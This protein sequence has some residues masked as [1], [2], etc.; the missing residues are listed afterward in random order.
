V[1][2]KACRQAGVAVCNVRGYSTPSVAQHTIALALALIE[3]L[4]Y[5][6]QFVKSGAY[7]GSG[8]FT[9]WGR[10]FGEVKG[11]TWGIFGMGAI[12]AEV[13]KVAEA[14]GAKVIYYSTQGIDRQPTYDR[15]E[16]EDFLSESDILSIHAPLNQHTSGRFGQSAFQKMKPHAVLLN[17]GRGGIVNIPELV[18]GPGD[19]TNC[20]SRFGRLPPKNLWIKI[21]LC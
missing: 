20:Q 5:W 11:K 12:G 4:E 14:L 10:T 7:S 6:D 16:W 1:D 17:L 15:L 8:A 21:V 18:W 13:A 3:P 19:W 9:H 2:I